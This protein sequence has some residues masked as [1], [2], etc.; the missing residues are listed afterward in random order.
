MLISSVPAITA[1]AVVL[2]N[3]PE[4]SSCERLALL[5]LPNTTITFAGTVAAGAFA[6]PAGT[7]PSG[8]LTNASFGTLPSFCRI[9]ATLKPTVDSD[10]KM[11]VWMPL[12]GWNGKFLAV[13]NGGWN[14]SITYAALAASLRRGY[15]TAS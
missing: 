2:L 9:A 10:I 11:E 15:A 3:Q 12:S 14:G 8:P 13:G 1:L 7:P 4:A 5:A 6:L